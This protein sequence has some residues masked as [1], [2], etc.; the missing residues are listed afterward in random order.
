MLS[1]KINVTLMD[2]ISYNRVNLLVNAFQNVDFEAISGLPF[3][4][5]PCV[6]VS[7][8]TGVCVDIPQASAL[9]TPL[10]IQLYGRV[11]G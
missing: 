4:L 1:S 3:P 9:G 6:P 11:Q 7:P 8:P 2:K 10:K 5:P